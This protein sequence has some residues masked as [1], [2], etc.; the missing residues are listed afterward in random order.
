M[1]T[2][3]EAPKIKAEAATWRN[4]KPQKRK[5]EAVNPYLSVDTKSDDLLTGFHDDGINVAI[6]MSKTKKRI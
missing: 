4:K 3:I 2:Q 6:N 1:R 5:Y